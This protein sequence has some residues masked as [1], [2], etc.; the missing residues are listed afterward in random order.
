MSALLIRRLSVFLL[1]L[2]PLLGHAATSGVS[3]RLDYCAAASSIAEDQPPVSCAWQPRRAL[4]IGDALLPVQWVRI[5]FEQNPA[6]TATPMAI[7]VMPHF[8]PLITL[9]SPTDNEKHWNTQV[10][11]IHSL[12]AMQHDVI[13]GY[14]FVVRPTQAS[15]IFYLKISGYTAGLPSIFIQPWPAQGLLSQVWLGMHLGILLLILAY[16]V[17]SYAIQPSELMKRFSTFMAVVVLAMLSGSGI[18]AQYVLEGLP[19]LDN[20]FFALLISTRLGLWVWLCQGFLITFRT[21]RWYR[22]ACWIIYGIVGLCV[23]LSLAQATYAMPSMII[24]SVI[25]FLAIQLVAIL[26]APEIETVLR[27]ILLAGFFLIE[28]ILVLMVFGALFFLEIEQLPL[29]MAR[30][31]DLGPALILSGMII[32]RDRQVRREF[33]SVRNELVALNLRNDFEQQAHKERRM[34]LDMLTHELKNPL[35]SIS[36]ATASLA[37]TTNMDLAAQPRLRNIQQSIESMDA[38]I[39][40]CSLVNAYGEGELKVTRDIVEIAPLMNEIIETCWQPERVRCSVS[41]AL[42]ISADRKLLRIVLANLIDNALKYATSGSM[43]EVTAGTTPINNRLL[44]VRN[45]VEPSLIPNPDLVFTRFYR[46]NDVHHV[47]GTGLGLFL[48]HALCERLGGSVRYTSTDNA[49]TFE[50]ELPE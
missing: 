28:L 5:H 29:Y 6:N 46:H 18:M 14:L 41:D 15:P 19:Q 8:I 13:G 7:Q 39:E 44:C 24:V 31:T 32:L 43:I 23:L 45:Q 34:M 47:S 40:R 9:Y 36:F 16:A 20:T 17:A 4:S 3:A 50:V 30:L 11:G 12:A 49:V 25:V 37:R 35:A 33:A 26:R 10:A 21:P 42:T 38:V 48:V 1:L 2:L 22:W 27:S